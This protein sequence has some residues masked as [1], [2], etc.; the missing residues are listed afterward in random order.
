MGRAQVNAAAGFIGCYHDCSST[1]EGHSS[2][3][4]CDDIVADV[5]SIDQC[6]ERCA[7]GYRYMGLACPRNGAFECWCC[8]EL[9]SNSAGKTAL[10]RCLTEI[11]TYMYPFSSDTRMVSSPACE[12]R[13]LRRIVTTPTSTAESMVIETITAPASAP[14]T[15]AATNSTGSA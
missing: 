3:R 8:N 11:P 9:D 5:V 15:A 4:V 12:D 6:K 10:V 14:R 13:C 2:D 1:T 7:G